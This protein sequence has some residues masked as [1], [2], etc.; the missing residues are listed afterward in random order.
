MSGSM[1]GSTIERTGF[2]VLA[3]SSLV[4]MEWPEIVVTQQPLE[5]KE[6]VERLGR[7]RRGGG[8]QRDG[9]SH[10]VSAVSKHVEFVEVS[11]LFSRRGRSR[12]G[13]E[14]WIHVGILCGRHGCVCRVCLRLG[15]IG[16]V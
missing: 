15:G 14:K 8:Y 9:F 4:V 16:R 3:W 13:I 11:S 2:V 10:R 7:K 1:R 5:E 12:G 6:E